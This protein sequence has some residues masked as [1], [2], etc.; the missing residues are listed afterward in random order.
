ME[1]PDKHL[2]GVLSW[3]GLSLSIGSSKSF[4][5][6]GPTTRGATAKAAQTCGGFGRN[7]SSGQRRVWL[8]SRANPDKGKEKKHGQRRCHLPCTG[9]GQLEGTQI[10]HYF[11]DISGAAVTMRHKKMAEQIMIN[12]R[13]RRRMARIEKKYLI[14]KT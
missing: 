2:V 10:G 6:R 8:Y 1:K 11:G 12:K 13:L 3:A 7:C 9:V 4:F 5:H 14:I